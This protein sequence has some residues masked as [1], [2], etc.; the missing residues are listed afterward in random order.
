MDFEEDDD[1]EGYL[2]DDSLDPDNMTYEV[3]WSDD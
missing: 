2:S 3:P 1:E